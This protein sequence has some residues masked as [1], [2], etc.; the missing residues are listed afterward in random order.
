MKFWRILTM[1]WYLEECV[2]SYKTFSSTAVKVKI[3]EVFSDTKCQ[4]KG[5]SQGVVISP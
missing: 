2:T 5:M 1:H 4:A 3:N